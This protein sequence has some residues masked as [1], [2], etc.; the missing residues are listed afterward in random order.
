MKTLTHALI[1]FQSNFEVILEMKIKPI[2]ISL[3]KIFV[4]IEGEVMLSPLITI[5]NPPIEPNQESLNCLPLL[6][7]EKKLSLK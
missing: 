7:K 5:F 3:K 4:S 6:P 1:C 2:K